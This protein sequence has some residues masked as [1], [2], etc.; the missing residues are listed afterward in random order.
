MDAVVPWHVDY[1]L[2]TGPWAQC[3]QELL[4]AREGGVLQIHPAPAA[5]RSAMT[6]LFEAGLA[7][8]PGWHWQVVAACAGLLHA[9]TAAPGEASLLGH[10]EEHL[11]NATGDDWTIDAV[12]AR[13][14][15]TRRQ[16]DFR[17]REARGEPIGGWLRRRRVERAAVLLTQGLSVA[18]TAAML[19][20][21]N[22]FHFSRVFK[23]IVGDS[24]AA[25]RDRARA[26][27]PLL[28]V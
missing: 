10:I 7:Q 2:L 12:A 26:S 5:G 18:D 20:Y 3:A 22:P 16:L 19:G 27:A 17:F 9:L 6:A 8:R 1:V 21:A 15:L 14:D 13:L 11:A 24:P 28:H 23:Q 25:Y 4:D